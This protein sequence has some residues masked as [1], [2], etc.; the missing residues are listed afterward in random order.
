MYHGGSFVRALLYLFP[1]IGL[2]RDHFSGS[3][4]CLS[5]QSFQFFSFLP[6]SF[7]QLPFSSLSLLCLTINFSRQNYKVNMYN[8]L[9]RCIIKRHYDNNS[10]FFSLLFLYQ[11]S[12]V[13][14][15]IL[16]CYSL[17][18]RLL[19]PKQTHDQLFLP[20]LFHN[21][22]LLSPT[23]LFLSMTPPKPIPKER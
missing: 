19:E 23:F 18:C 7:Y 16:L 20:T 10:N 21:S 12:D 22:F 1:D 5:S 13:F 11:E 8:I 2:V 17:F 9:I 4:V 3:K 15:I 14:C 6:L